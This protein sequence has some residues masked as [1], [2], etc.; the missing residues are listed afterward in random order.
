MSLVREPR[1]EDPDQMALLVNMNSG[2]QPDG[3]GSTNDLLD[4]LSAASDSRPFLRVSPSLIG[5]RP[6]A[7]MPAEKRLPLSGVVTKVYEGG[8]EEVLR[9]YLPLLNSIVNRM[10]VSLPAHVEVED[11]VSAGLV[12]L[13][14]AYRRFDASQGASFGTY[15]AGRIRGAVLDE[16]RRSDWMSR[17]SRS[18]AK[19]VSDTISGF[20]QA[21]GRP[22]TEEDIAG[23][24]AL[25]T[26]EY[27]SLLDEIRP[28]SYVS[29]DAS[30]SSGETDLMH[31][32]VA[33][34]R[35]APADQE[36]QKRELSAMVAE[37]IQ[38]MP[39]MTRK[40]LAMY[41]FEE[42]RLSE[43][44]EVFGVT[45]SRICQINAHAIL[46]LRRFM[47]SMTDS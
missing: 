30:P 16:M 43:I 32:M 24:L 20:E 46:S 21:H 12:G 17:S 11:L 36:A 29:L 27:A 25:S 35:A 33:D 13:V 6:Q 45:E 18:K 2:F 47:Q 40:V 44:A 37:R 7:H 19:L 8:E 39:E 14:Q 42:M 4:Q 26:G 1:V 22:A 41:Y 3:E 31:E 5:S 38:Q 34:E 10:R 28:L 23:E 15:A 9:K